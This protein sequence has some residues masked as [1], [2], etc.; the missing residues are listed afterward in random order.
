MLLGLALFYVGAVLFLNGIWVM[1]YIEDREISVIN[2]FVGTL[3]LLVSLFLALGPNADLDSVRAAAFTLLFTFT[4]YWVAWNR[5]ERR[6]RPRPRL[7][8]LLRRHYRHLHH[9]RCLRGRRQHPWSL[10]GHLLGIMGDSVAHV[11]GASRAQEADRQGDGRLLLRKWRLHGVDTGIPSAH[12]SAQLE[13]VR[14]S[15]HRSPRPGSGFPSPEVPAAG[16][17]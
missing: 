12:R 13:S 2:V 7:V 10:A 9:F 11:L 6:R 15:L 14:Q 8:L 4:Y 16:R 5:W 3:T 17:R 1:G